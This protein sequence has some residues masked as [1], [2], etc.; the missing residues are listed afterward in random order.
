[1]TFF[2]DKLKVEDLIIRATNKNYFSPIVPTQKLKPRVSRYNKILR[3][4]PE[5]RMSSICPVGI[6]HYKQLSIPTNTQPRALS[7]SPI[8]SLKISSP[9]SPKPNTYSLLPPLRNSTELCNY[10]PIPLKNP[11]P[12]LRFTM[13]GTNFTPKSKFLPVLQEKKQK[14]SAKDPKT[15]KPNPTTEDHL[16]GWE[17][18]SSQSSLFH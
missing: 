11:T 3:F 16:H 9:N 15:Q 5:S 4:Y 8:D 1:M 7:Q 2:Q 14:N 10:T 17:K 18:T 6:N 12:S 13:Y